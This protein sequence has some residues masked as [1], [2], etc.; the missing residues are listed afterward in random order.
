MIVIATPSIPV[1]NDPVRFG[2]SPDSGS[3]SHSQSED[4]NKDASQAPGEY[5]RDPQ[6]H[7]PS[8]RYPTRPKAGIP[9]ISHPQRAAAILPS[10][11]PGDWDD[12]TIAANVIWR[13]VRSIQRVERLLLR[14]P[15]PLLG[16]SCTVDK[17]DLM[18]IRF[19]A[20]ILEVRYHRSLAVTLT[21]AEH[22]PR[23]LRHALDE[24]NHYL[25]PRQ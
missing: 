21:T 24:S 11:A 16:I 18:G 22:E 23:R 25:R 14:T 6:T 1:P 17:F 2:G 15:A 3:H 13:V 4:G 7:A 19:G 8:G 10:Q 20:C 5:H 12:S 9:A